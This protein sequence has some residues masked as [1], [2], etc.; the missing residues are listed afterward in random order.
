MDNYSSKYGNFILLGDLNSEP[1]ESA[2]KDF[3]E[4]HSCR[5]LIKDN[6]CFKNPLKLPCIDLIITNR[7]KSFQN[8]VTVQTGLSDFHKMTLIVINVF[9]K[10]QK[11]N[12]VTYWNY[13]NFSN[14]AFMLDVKNS[15]IQITSENNDLEFDRFKTALD[16]AI[17]RHAPIIKR[18]VRANQGP[19]IN[20]KI[21]KEIMKR[22]RLRNKFLNTKSDIDRKAYNKQRNL[23]VDLIRRKKK[24]FFSNINMSEITDNKT[25]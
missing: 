6:T 7:R 24:N 21:N 10:K 1:T 23:C 14:E 22:S 17:Q 2:V 18:Y 9:Y 19:F 13:K 3:C 4:I 11:T 5:N 12:I 16:E 25:F 8:S 20:K 15:I